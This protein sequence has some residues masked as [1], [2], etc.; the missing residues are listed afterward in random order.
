[1][2]FKELEQANI[3]DAINIV[4][5]LELHHKNYTREQYYKILDLAA[6]LDKLKTEV[7]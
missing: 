4:E 1:M 5:W 7:K 2:T 3:Q 6:I